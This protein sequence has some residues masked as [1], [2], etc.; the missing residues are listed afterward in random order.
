MTD[1][2]NAPGTADDNKVVPLYAAAIIALVFQFLPQPALQVAS[3]VLLIL[4]GLALKA[5]SNHSRDGTLIHN[6][7]VYLSRTVKIWSLFL[8]V[9]IVIAGLYMQ[10]KYDFMQL[11]NI[12][13]SLASGK[14]ENEDARRFT[15]VGVLAM[16][17]STIYLVYR[18]AKGFMF[19]LR[20]RALA[21]PRG[22][23]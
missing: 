10:T 8:F 13:Q 14:I 9:T 4:F 7:A 12:V 23:F 1:H 19:A 15:Y 21:K 11:I 18:V 5:Y 22:I 6:H 3:I 17:P 20:G 16:A 2:E